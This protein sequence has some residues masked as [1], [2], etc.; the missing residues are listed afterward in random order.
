MLGIKSFVVSNQCSWAA[1]GSQFTSDDMTRVE[2]GGTLSCWK[3]DFCPLC[4]AAG[5]GQ[6]GGDWVCA[7]PGSPACQ[8]GAELLGQV[9]N[10]REK[11]F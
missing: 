7:V 9:E 4:R 3:G 10:F 8:V 2:I 5:G 6:S 1:A 11:R